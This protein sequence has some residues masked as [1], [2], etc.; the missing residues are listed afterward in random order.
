MAPGPPYWCTGSRLWCAVS[1]FGVRGRDFKSPR[2]FSTSGFLQPIRGRSAVN[3]D[4]KVV[5]FGAAPTSEVTGA[6]GGED[7]RIFRNVPPAAI[8]ARSTTNP[9]R[10]QT[11]PQSA[12]CSGYKPRRICAACGSVIQV[13]RGLRAERR[14]GLSM[15]R[16]RRYRGIR[17][18]R[19]LGETS[20]LGIRKNFPTTALLTRVR[21]QS[22]RCWFDL[23]TT[24]RQH[25]K[26]NAHSTSRPRYA[27]GRLLLEFGWL[28]AGAGATRTSARIGQFSEHHFAGH[29]PIS[30]RAP[31]APIN[32]LRLHIH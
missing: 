7:G 6:I 18:A 23:L 14:P 27:C 19:S 17:A 30:I 24:A 21:A 10:S 12:Y 5:V 1:G 32:N 25:S 29:A 20:G 3:R 16:E 8:P 26:N 31:S 9:Y 28:V 4:G 13:I 22:R 2:I 15:R 11:F